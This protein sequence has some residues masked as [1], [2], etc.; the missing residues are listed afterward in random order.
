MNIV[1]PFDSLDSQVQ[2]FVS[3]AWSRA[4]QWHT[5]G[6]LLNVYFFC[7][8]NRN[9]QG[10]SDHCLNIYCLIVNSVLLY[11][12]FI[13][14]VVIRYPCVSSLRKSEPLS[15][16]GVSSLCSTRLWTSYS[17]KVLLIPLHFLSSRKSSLV[18]LASGL[19]FY[20]VSYKTVLKSTNKP[21]PPP[22]LFI[23]FFH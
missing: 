15:S 4:G 7:V 14:T 21:P 3:S 23:W 10:M 13:T 5:T 1:F 18:T 2:W 11:L 19:P 20:K 8:G 9:S 12:Q 22:R 16:F 6:H 17:S